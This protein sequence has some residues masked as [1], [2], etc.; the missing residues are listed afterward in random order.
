MTDYSSY[1]DTLWY[2]LR[3]KIGWIIIDEGTTT[4]GKNAF[5]NYNELNALMNLS[6]AIHIRVNMV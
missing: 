1:K 6:T 3:D 4:I 2:D 5:T